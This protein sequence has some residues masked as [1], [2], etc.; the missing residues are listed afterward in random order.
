MLTIR[1]EQIEA[2]ERA[3][4]KRFI[5]KTIDF[6]RTNSPEWRR[7]S[8]ETLTAFVETMISFAEEHGLRKE[9]S[10]Q[11]L[12]AYKITDQFAI[13]LPSQLEL[14]LRRPG[15]DEDSRLEYFLRQLE[16]MSPLIKLRLE[17]VAE[18]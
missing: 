8:D 14:I 9:I 7:Q 4:M 11:K 17:D 1:K 5:G 13:P 2:M 16:D 10:I 6:I 15:L 12:I 3:G 18:N